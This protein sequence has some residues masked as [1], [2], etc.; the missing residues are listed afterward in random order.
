MVS[1]P[2]LCLAFMPWLP[3]CWTTRNQLKEIL[4]SPLTQV[5]YVMVLSSAIESK[6]W[7]RSIGLEVSNTVPRV[8]FSKKKKQSELILWFATKNLD[9]FS[10]QKRRRLKSVIQRCPFVWL[11]MWHWS[12]NDKYY[13]PELGGFVPYYF[14]WIILLHFLATEVFDVPQL[15]LNLQCSYFSLPSAGAP[16]KCQHAWL[17]TCLK[18]G[19]NTSNRPK[20]LDKL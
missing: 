19:A 14:W 9:L 7:Q 20:Q 11:W 1:A 16:G 4:S 8:F 12:L 10:R 5:V 17:E 18:R 13:Y 15:A 3:R 6:L 2:G